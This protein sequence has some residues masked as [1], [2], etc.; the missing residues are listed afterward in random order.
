MPEAVA[1]PAPAAASTPAPVSA[2]VSSA[3][4][5][6]HVSAPAATETAAPVSTGSPKTALKLSDFTNTDD[7]TKALFEEQMGMV[8][9]DEGAVIEEPAAEE[10]AA[11]ETEVTA[12]QPETKVEEPEEPEFELNPP[13]IA[14]PEV[15][16]RLITEN[17][18]FAK[19]LEADPKLKGQL[20]KTAREAAELKP[21]RE[22]FPDLESAKT[23]QAEVQTWNGIRSTFMNSTSREGANATLA[24]MMQ[25]C[26]ERDDAGNVVKGPDGNPVIGDDF[27]GFVDN[28]VAQDLEHRRDDVKARLEANQYHI[29]AK[30]QEEANEAYARDAARLAFLEDELGEVMEAPAANDLPPALQAKAAEIERRERE[31]NEKQQ[32]SKVQG[33]QEYEKAV[34]TATTDR[35][36][37]AIN[38]VIASVK[39]Q[40]GAISPYLEKILPQAIGNKLMEKLKAD[41]ALAGRLQELQRLPATDA[42]KQ[43]RLAEVDRAIQNYLPE[44]ARAELREAGV[45]VAA[46]AK[47]KL[48]KIA[49]QEE[50]SQQTE[51]KGSTGAAR[52]NGKTPLSTND[53]DKIATEE[54]KKANPGRTFDRAAQE[55]VIPRILQLMTGT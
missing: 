50:R 41:T 8:P 22:I 45:Q 10:P 28:V 38:G 33:R 32:G 15:M 40:G 7:Y 2:P 52:V 53:A 21:Y 17:P 19:V 11:V 39:K 29:G 5:S 3:P 24:Q 20:Y 51:P 14:T 42:N 31:L 47:A 16:N 43:R 35:V 54:W 49:G 12:E 30:T 37:T 55:S 27:F 36:S 6:A 34:V 26:Y 48:A 13:E 4:V 44:V 25:L 46:N 18:E 9:K 1:A 23:A